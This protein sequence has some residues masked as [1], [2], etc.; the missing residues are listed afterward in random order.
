MLCKKFLPTILFYLSGILQVCLHRNPVCNKQDLRV[1]EGL[2]TNANVGETG[3]TRFCTPLKLNGF[4]YRKM[5]V[6]T[7][8]KLGIEL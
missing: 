8:L 2:C 7:L 6:K 1:C 4:D 3:E 5:Q